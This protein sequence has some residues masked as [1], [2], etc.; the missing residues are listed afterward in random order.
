MIRYQPTCI[1]LLV[2]DSTLE[3]IVPDYFLS[4]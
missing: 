4:C 3:I 1:S 2:L